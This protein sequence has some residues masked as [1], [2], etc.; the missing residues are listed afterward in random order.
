MANDITPINS[1]M[2]RMDCN[3]DALTN[4]KYNINN[5]KKNHT[6]LIATKKY[7]IIFYLLKQTL[8]N[9]QSHYLNISFYMFQGYHLPNPDNS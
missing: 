8:S 6:T 7:F 4:V 5:D 3:W 1:L 2:S 9:V